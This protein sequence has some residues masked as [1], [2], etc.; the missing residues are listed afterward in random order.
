MSRTNTPFPLTEW[1]QAARSDPVM[2][3]L[4]W[5]RARHLRKKALNDLQEASRPAPADPSPRSDGHHHPISRIRGSCEAG[6]T[7]W[8]DLL[9]RAMIMERIK[10]PPAPATLSFLEPCPAGA[11]SVLKGYSNRPKE[12][13][14]D[15]WRARIE[16][17]VDQWPSLASLTPPSYA[18][19]PNRE[20]HGHDRLRRRP[21]G[22]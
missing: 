10:F 16:Y 17:V 11:H 9:R 20:R 14:S 13:D 7:S 3:S 15:I 12:V 22:G 6:A 2:R 4:C 8:E 1:R 21:Y 18:R 19:Q 5:R